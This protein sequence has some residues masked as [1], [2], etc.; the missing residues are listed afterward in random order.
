[1]DN[2]TFDNLLRIITG[3]HLFE[4]LPSTFQ[5]NLP[6][7]GSLPLFFNDKK[8]KNLA[9]ILLS[10]ADLGKKEK[11]LLSSTIYQIFEKDDIDNYELYAVI[12]ECLKKHDPE[13]GKNMKLLYQK[14]KCNVN[15]SIQIRKFVAPYLGIIIEP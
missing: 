5:T 11:E 7:V 2:V 8:V 6:I 12:G 3:E 15:S 1:M 9:Y 10:L 13:Y 4:L 14:V